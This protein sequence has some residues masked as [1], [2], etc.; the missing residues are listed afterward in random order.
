MIDATDEIT[1]A[2]GSVPREQQRPEQLDGRHRAEVVDRDRVGRVGGDSRARHDGV[3]R[4]VRRTRHPGDHRQ[5]TLRRRQVGDHVGI[6]QIDADDPVA[7]HRS[8]GGVV[9][10]PMPDADPVTT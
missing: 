3:D 5:A 1:T 4:P 7:V 8:A 10:A 6:L 9:A 2:R